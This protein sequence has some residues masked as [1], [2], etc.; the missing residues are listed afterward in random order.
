MVEAVQH[1]VP[2]GSDIQI[3]ADLNL[4]IKDIGYSDTDTSFVDAPL[5]DLGIP[6][7]PSMAKTIAWLRHHQVGG[8]TTWHTRG[9]YRATRFLTMHDQVDKE[10]SNIDMSV[11]TYL[12]ANTSWLRVWSGSPDPYSPAHSSVVVQ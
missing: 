7:D 8:E 5:L 9:G 6:I 4:Q 10:M 3:W 1:T 11:I 12:T 2:D